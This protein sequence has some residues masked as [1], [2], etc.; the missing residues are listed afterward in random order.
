MRVPP[1]LRR[2]RRLLYQSCLALMPA[3]VACWLLGTAHGSAAGALGGLSITVL[4]AWLWHDE[5]SPD[6]PR[7]PARLPANS[8]AEP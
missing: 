3:G 4:G 7:R 1:L 8:H 2:L 5:E 6:H